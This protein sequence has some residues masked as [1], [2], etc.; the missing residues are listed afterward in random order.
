MPI[1][2]RAAVALLVTILVA[3]PLAFPPDSQVAADQLTLRII[4]LNSADEAERVSQ[5]IANGE[6]FI[7]LAT[8]LSLDPSGPSG[9]LLGHVSVSALRPELQRALEG[10]PVGQVSKVVR[11][12]TG[13][14]LLKIVPDTE[15][16]EAPSKVSSPNA[17][18][19]A[20]GSVKYALD[21]SGMGEALVAMNQFPHPAD[22]NVDPHDLCEMRKASMGAV[23]P[24]SSK[25][26]RRPPTPIH[27]RRTT[28]W[29][30]L[31]LSGT[32]GS[33]NRGAAEGSGDRPHEGSV[34]AAAPRGDARRRVPPPCWSRE[35][36]VSAAWRLLPA[37]PDRSPRV[38][39]DRGL[40]EGRRVFPAV[41]VGPSGR[42]R[43]EMAAQSRIHDDGGV[44]GAGSAAHT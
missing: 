16:H 43:S 35:R 30:D 40:R 6:N 13:F 8:Q 34:H 14:A 10:L 2:F 32:D 37:D 29:P 42:P 1:G 23:R 41:S 28:C 12:P 31:R 19:A 20:T 4:V 3:S 27:C 39:E 25:I 44:S 36:S 18:L 38:L 26:C 15:T 24:R 7:A 17:A 33:R 9:G 21:L 11:I 22:W 5:R